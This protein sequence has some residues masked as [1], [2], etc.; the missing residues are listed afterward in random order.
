M[1]EEVTHAFRARAAVPDLPALLPEV[2]LHWDHKTV[3]ERGAHALLGQRMAFLLLT[4]HHRIVLEVD[5]ATHYTDESGTASWKAY[6]RNAALDRSIRLRGYEVFRF[7]G[8]ELHTEEQARSML[9]TFF[10]DLFVH[11][12][13]MGDLLLRSRAALGMRSR[14]LLRGPGRPR[15]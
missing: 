12:N 3:R 9:T 15:S 8:A 7:G 4:R 6:A 11:Y 13:V 5:G 1:A 2:W 14:P 10:R